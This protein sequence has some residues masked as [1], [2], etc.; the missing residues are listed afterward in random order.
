MQQPARRQLRY[1]ALALGAILI[2]APGVHV[3]ELW[4][5]PTV[6]FWVSHAL[7]V[8]ALATVAWR[9]RA[10]RAKADRPVGPAA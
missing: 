10:T 2:A 3:F 4:L 7:A 5:D 1:G 9:W 6:A 8:G